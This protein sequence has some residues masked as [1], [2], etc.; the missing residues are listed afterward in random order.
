MTRTHWDDLARQWQHVGPPL[1]PSSQDIEFC[2]T[3]IHAWSRDKGAP[4]ALILGVT[5][6]LYHL[7]WPDGTDLLAVDHTQAMIDEVWPGPRHAAICAEWTTMPFETGSRDIVLCD[8]GL[9]MLTYPEVLRQFARTLHRILSAEG[10]CVFRVFV[11]PQQRESASHVLRDLLEGRIPNISALKLR[12][13][14]ALQE[15]SAQG[16]ELERVW[17]AVHRVAADLAQLA[18][19]I[20]W[21]VE[22]ALALTTYRTSPIRYCLFSLDE[23]RRVFCRDPAR[24]ELVTVSV[25]TYAL[26]DCCPTI[27]LRRVG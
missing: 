12:L 5:P 8:G 9:H 3:A 25:P 19:R 27:V 10:I 4:R 18:L 23:A 22:H 21:P 24:F 7:P 17:D 26:G 6:E 1:R 15:S 20:G 13:W 11:P 16:V 2:A 14:M